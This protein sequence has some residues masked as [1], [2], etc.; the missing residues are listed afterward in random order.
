MT[1]PSG[2]ETHASF[3]ISTGIDNTPAL[4]EAVQAAMKANPDMH[5]AKL[6]ILL[7]DTVLP[8]KI[9]GATVYIGALCEYLEDEGF[10]ENRPPAPVPPPYPPEV[11]GREFFEE[12]RASTISAM[13]RGMGT[14][15]KDA[16]YAMFFMHAEKR[17]YTR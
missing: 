8:E 6:A 2:H 4:Y 7:R 13:A 5:R 9:N 12:V 10:P 14:T 11:T 1:E 15:E 16:L 3:L 17:G